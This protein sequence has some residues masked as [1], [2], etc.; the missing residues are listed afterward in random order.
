MSK[1][2]RWDTPFTE[3]FYP[4]VALMATILPSIVGNVDNLKVVV[5]PHEK[6]FPKCLVDFGNVLAFTCMDEACCPERDFPEVPVEVGRTC[7][8]QYIDSPWLKSYEGCHDPDAEGKFSHYL[9][10]GGDRII[11][12]I[13]QNAPIIR[14]LKQKETLIIKFET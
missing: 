4:L 2:I 1:L 10:V 8:Y 5:D 12:I 7:A 11:E 9:I 14:T 3:A 6:E 13:T